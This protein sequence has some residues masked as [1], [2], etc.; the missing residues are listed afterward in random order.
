MPGDLT[1]VKMILSQAASALGGFRGSALRISQE[2]I[3]TRVAHLKA[4]ADNLNSL[5]GIVSAMINDI[6][7]QKQLVIGVTS[8]HQVSA[9][10]DALGRIDQAREKL[11]EMRTQLNRSV[12]QIDETMLTTRSIDSLSSDFVTLAATAANDLNRYRTSF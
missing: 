2:V 8:G 11:V 4:A 6:D 5:A 12:A 3:D 9:P 7:E 10:S 1:Y